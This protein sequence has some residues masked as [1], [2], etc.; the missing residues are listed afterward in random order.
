MSSQNLKNFKSYLSTRPSGEVKIRL[1]EDAVVFIPD[2]GKLFFDQK[3][4]NTVLS[5]G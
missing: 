3:Y 2:A 1:Y 4:Y 5:G